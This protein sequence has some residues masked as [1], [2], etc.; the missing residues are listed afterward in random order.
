MSTTLEEP[1]TRDKAAQAPQLMQVLKDTSLPDSLNTRYHSSMRLGLGRRIQS[2]A[3][4][5]SMPF[6]E[7]MR[8]IILT[9]IKA[10]EE[11]ADKERR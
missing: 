4:A 1:D 8:V 5:N 10:H 9:G 3:D 2:L 11:R 7:M 6:A